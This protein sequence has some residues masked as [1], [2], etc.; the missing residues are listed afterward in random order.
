MAAFAMSL[1]D[2]DDLIAHDT[3]GL[4]PVWMRKVNTADTR[5]QWQWYLHD[6]A[7]LGFDGG[8]S[9]VRALS[10]VGSHDRR[11][12][13]MWTARLAQLMHGASV[14]QR[15]VAARAFEVALGLI[16]AHAG[17]VVAEAN[18]GESMRLR[19]LS[20]K[21]FV[22][23]GAARLRPAGPWAMEALE[24]D[25]T[26]SRGCEELAFLV[27]DYF[28]EWTH[29]LLAGARAALASDRGA[30]HQGEVA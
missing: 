3:K 10:N 23:R 2:L 25:S 19:F 29:E 8:T 22:L 24:L 7:V 15:L 6:L 1:D 17:K 20:Q 28:A 5:H 27:F 21:P 13:R 11:L 9:V 30:K 26:E 18:S 14:A 4:S 16:F 12:G